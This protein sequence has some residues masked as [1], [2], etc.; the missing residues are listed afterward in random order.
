MM[1]LTTILSALVP[2]GVEGLKDWIGSKTGPVAKTVD[3]QIKLDNA[4][5]ARLEAVAKL[6][7]P[8]GSP[9][10]WVVDLRAASRYIAALIVILGGVIAFYIPNL[11]VGA[12]AFAGDAVSIVF[13][14]LFGTRI[15]SKGK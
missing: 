5:V 7:N 3:E 15:V 8:Y 4:D 6:D 10:Q 14:F 11:P 9:S 12:L 2:V 1:L 13:G